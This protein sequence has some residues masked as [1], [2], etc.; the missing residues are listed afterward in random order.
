MAAP[1]GID[2]TSRRMNLEVDSDKAAGSQLLDLKA[3]ENIEI[4]G[5][6]IKEIEIRPLNN[7]PEVLGVAA[8]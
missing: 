4:N 3:L 5:L 7:L 6:Y 1:G 8:S 2:L